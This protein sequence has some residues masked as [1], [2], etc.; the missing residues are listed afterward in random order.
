MTSH[1][2]GKSHTTLQTLDS[3]VGMPA[4]D[5]TTFQDDDKELTTDRYV[6]F[7]LCVC[8]CARAHVCVYAL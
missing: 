5:L 8:E 2:V 3:V 4:M 6:L 7:I 1:K